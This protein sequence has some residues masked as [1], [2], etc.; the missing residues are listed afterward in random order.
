MQFIFFRGME[1]V[2]ACRC[3]CVHMCVRRCDPPSSARR[4]S[5]WGRLLCSPTGGGGLLL[6]ATRRPQ[7]GWP[8]GPTR[9]GDLARFCP[10]YLKRGDRNFRSFQLCVWHI[11]RSW[12]ISTLCGCAHWQSPLLELLWQTLKLCSAEMHRFPG[13]HS[14]Q[15]L[16]KIL[17]RIVHL[18]GVKREVGIRRTTS[19]TQQDHIPGAQRCPGRPWGGGSSG[20]CW[21]PAELMPGTFSRPA[22]PLVTGCAF[23]FAIYF[24]VK[25]TVLLKK[26]KN[27]TK[28]N[29]CYFSIQIILK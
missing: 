9:S 20:R 18:I 3:V 28:I 24:Q 26:K 22:E 27:K 19:L 1:N 5:P 15:T 2:S 7:A 25:R 12:S 14:S 4:M 11:Q 8:P 13:A 6:P 21:A 23:A 10:C 16:E 29:E 17:L